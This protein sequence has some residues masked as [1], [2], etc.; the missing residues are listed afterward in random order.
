MS[1]VFLVS[2]KVMSLLI[3]AVN[4]FTRTLFPTISAM[5]PKSNLFTKAHVAPATKKIAH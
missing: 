5:Y 1:P 4:N 3:V 2:K